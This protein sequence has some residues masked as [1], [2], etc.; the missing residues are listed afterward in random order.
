[1]VIKNIELPI[2]YQQ[3]KTSTLNR[4]KTI[5]IDKTV[6]IKKYYTYAEIAINIIQVLNTLLKVTHKRGFTIAVNKGYL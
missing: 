2:T 3:S 4:I 1:L 5:V 6:E